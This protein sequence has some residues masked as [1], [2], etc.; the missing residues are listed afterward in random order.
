MEK[1]KGR[2]RTGADGRPGAPIMR[3]RCRAPILSR[4]ASRTQLR[5]DP[6]TAPD[7]RPEGVLFVFVD[8]IGLGDDDPGHNPLAVDRPG[9]LA[10]SG[11]VRWI[12][13]DGPTSNGAVFHSIDAC[14]GVDGYPQSGTGQ[15]TLFTGENCARLAGRHYGPFPHST[16][17]PALRSRSIFARIGADRCAFANAFP[18]RYFE[19]MQARD[20][21]P[22]MTRACLDAGV[23]VRTLAELR[24]GDAIAAD[25]TGR[26]LR[27][28]GLDVEVLTPAGTAANALR[29]AGRHRLTVV[30]I[31]HTD[32]AG[33]ARDRA[34]AD[35]VLDDLDAFLSALVSKRTD[36]LLVVLTSDHG[37]LEDLRVRTHTRNP[38]PFAALGPG[39]GRLS[40]VR[41]LVDVTPAL[42]GLVGGE[43]DA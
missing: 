14:L 33:H 35:R 40:G 34:A 28:M 31:F 15:A 7:A 4:M 29:L 13:G 24:A 2:A 32:K 23:P 6:G 38:V 12:S 18:P 8:G 41:S 27:D 11:G 43:R 22:V 37:N 17:R 21:W 1:V 10:M 30:E 25:L 19:I 42:V 39:A 9:F 3:A 36:G 16:S 26:G 20:R 5:P